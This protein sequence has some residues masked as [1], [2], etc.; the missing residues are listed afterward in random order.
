MQLKPQQNQKG[1]KM[2]KILVLVPLVI[3]AIVLVVLATTPARADL[4]TLLKNAELTPKTP[5][6]VYRVETQ[7]LD[8]RV[9]EFKPE[10]NPNMTCLMAWGQ[11]HPAGLQCFEDGVKE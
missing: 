11:T 7:G 5:T 1:L 10:G 4:W 2:T 6:S 8:V 9:Y 3:S